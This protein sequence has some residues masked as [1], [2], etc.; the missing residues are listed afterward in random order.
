MQRTIH[1]ATA[2]DEAYLLPLHVTVAS[3]QKRLSS[4]LTPRLYLLNRSLSRS[5]VDSIA[6]L[7]DTCPIV[8]GDAAIR[9]L[10]RQAGFPPE[11]SFPLLL[12]DV[13]PGDVERV[14]FLDPD[15]LVLDDIAEI[16]DTP[17]GSNTIAAARDLAMP[18]CSSPRAVKKCRN[19]GIPHDAPYFNA[20]VMLIDIARW[21]AADVSSQ[22][23]DYLERNRGR[24]DYSHQEGL[25]A[26]LW[27]KWKQLDQRWN[28]IASLTG[29]RYSSPQQNVLTAGIVHFAGRFKP[30]HFKVGG[31]FGDSYAEALQELGFDPAS[32]WSIPRSLLSVYDRYFRDYLYDIEHTFWMKRLT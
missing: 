19:L 12:S 29:R 11:V 8:P 31:P 30:W 25:N 18:T 32:P 2:I 27:D 1:I 22:V 16:W 10:P 28:L 14:L 6:R 5:A 4:S 23:G 9:E 17:L 13:L 7:I 24:T 15:L 3:L 20:G 21:K 26:V